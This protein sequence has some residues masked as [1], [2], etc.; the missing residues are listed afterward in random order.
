MPY[1][2][3]L[4]N[5]M[6]SQKFWNA[7]GAIICRLAIAHKPDGFRKPEMTRQQLGM[8]AAECP[9]GLVTNCV[10]FR[11]VPAYSGTEL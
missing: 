6:L 9:V 11:A 7:A 4:P 5:P 10:L 8:T 1:V 3:F 2:I